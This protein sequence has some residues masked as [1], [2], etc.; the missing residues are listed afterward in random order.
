MEFN[1]KLNKIVYQDAQRQELAVIEYQPRIN[2]NAVWEITRTFVDP[3][4]RGQGIAQ[5][6]LNHLVNLAIKNNKQLDPICSYAK[7]AFANSEELQ[8]LQ[9]K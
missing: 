2:D 7:T 6:L 3:S 4:L 8:T 9:A 5:Q 1:F